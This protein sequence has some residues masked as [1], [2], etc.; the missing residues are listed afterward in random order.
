MEI[1]NLNHFPSVPLG[2]ITVTVSYEALDSAAA[3]VLQSAQRLENVCETLGG[4]CDKMP[5][6][7][8]SE[9]CQLNQEIMRDQVEQMR[10]MIRRV[11]VNASNL[12]AIAQNYLKASGDAGS[13]IQ[14]L[15]SDVIV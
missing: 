3:S 14:G 1:Q 9:A 5:S 12:Q 15:S 11:R 8:E 4:Q 10:E 13:V 2:Q 7:W 6:Y